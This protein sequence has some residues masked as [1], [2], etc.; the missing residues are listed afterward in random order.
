MQP[1]TGQTEAKQSWIKVVAAGKKEGLVVWSFF[2]APGASTERHAREFEQL[3]GIRVELAP[4]RTAATSRRLNAE[5][6]A[7]KASI[8]IR[9]SGSLGEP[10]PR[11]PGSRSTL[12]YASGSGRARCA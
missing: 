6:A 7:G 5:R 10:A 4:A 1:G 12:R 3:H 2:G 9:S 11:R 8:D